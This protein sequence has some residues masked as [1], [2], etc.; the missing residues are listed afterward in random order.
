MPEL[1]WKHILTRLGWLVDL[2]F[3][4]LADQSVPKGDV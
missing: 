1:Y 2:L 3:G 4:A